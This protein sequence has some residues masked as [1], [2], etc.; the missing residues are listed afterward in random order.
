MSDMLIDHSGNVRF[1]HFHVQMLKIQ[2]LAPNFPTL[3]HIKKLLTV[4]EENKISIS[5]K[6][7]QLKSWVQ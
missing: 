2:G 7:E 3:W 4:P 6:Q 5:D 1:N